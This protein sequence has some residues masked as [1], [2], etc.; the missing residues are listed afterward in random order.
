MVMYY[1]MSFWRW[2]AKL[3]CKWRDLWAQRTGAAQRSRPPQRCMP[4]TLF[5][6]AERASAWRR[7]WRDA[8]WSS[9]SID[10]FP[11]KDCVFFVAFF[12]WN[13]GEEFGSVR[14]RGVRHRYSNTALRGRPFDARLL[15]FFLACSSGFETW[16]LINMAAACHSATT[17]FR[18]DFAA[19]TII[20][21]RLSISPL[22]VPANHEL[23]CRS[24]EI[25]GPRANIGGGF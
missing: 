11:Q 24:Q 1:D 25:D 3:G 6:S 16:V 15:V 13:S 22:V 14:A 10:P 4:L 5:P 17:V 7:R 9:D 2:A 12:A 8:R 23:C 21:F 20:I 19:S 18:N